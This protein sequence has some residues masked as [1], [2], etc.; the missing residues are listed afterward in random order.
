[1]SQRNKSTIE[2][3]QEFHEIFEHPVHHKPTLSD[4]KTND[5]RV[6]LLRE[7]LEE[8]EEALSNKDSADVLDA[9][10]DLQYVLDGAYLALG[11]HTVKNA[12]FEEVHRSNM[13]KLG[14]NGEVLRRAGDGKILKG[15]NYFKPDL[16][17][18]IVKA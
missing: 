9:L 18:F 15:E 1:M 12:A 4:E 2:Q 7:E 16:A 17:Q 8:L 3:V 5:L 10:T 14:K 11:L 6:S 13:S